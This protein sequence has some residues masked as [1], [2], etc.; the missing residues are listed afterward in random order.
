MRSKIALILCLS[1]IVGLCG[2][3]PSRLRTPGTFYYL[4]TETA[5]SGSDGVF[6][7]E[8]R[9]L[10]G[11]R[12]DPMAMLE[13]YCRGPI[14]TGLEN[15]LPAGT[16]VLSCTVN[17]GILALNFTSQLAQLDG[18]ELTAAAGCLAHTFLK[19]TDSRTLILKAD[20]ALLGGQTSMTI[21]LDD[22]ELQD[23]SLERYFRD[24]T[25]Y[26]TDQNRR[27]LIGQEIPL[28]F[29]EPESI[30]MQLLERLTTP[31]SDSTLHSPL[32]LGTRVLSATVSD[33]LCTV[34]LSAEFENRRFYA[35][36]SQVLSLMGVVNTLTALPEI[37]RVEFVC[38][39]SLLL[40]YGS[41]NIADPLVRDERCIGPVRTALSE[42]DV[43]LYLSHGDDGRLIPVPTRLRQTGV[44]SLAELIV[45][46]LLQDPGING[47]RTRIPAGTQLN[48]VTVSEGIC[49]V[50]LSAQYLSS[51]DNL[52]WAGRV[53]AASLCP[54]PDVEQVQI[55][56]DGG[57]PENFD[58]SWFGPL[59]PSSDW[60]L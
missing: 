35:L 49:Y 43:T 31:P 51:P 41:L 34:E 25:V 27:Y 28:D 38:D 60:F 57:F 26:Y 37:H 44:V 11:I 3:Q 47:I 59:S 24:F 14:T 42:Q 1:L 23:H 40:H 15:P 16:S 55:L 46:Q 21:S 20:G 18:I 12:Q 54:L 52:R 30:P 32:P 29:S 36:T 17:S 39:G 9:E 50:D 4:R 45:R 48:A 33:G 13:L 53:I 6:A 2:C 19:L 22:L 7:P 5:Y 56:I 8:Q 58:R 10:D